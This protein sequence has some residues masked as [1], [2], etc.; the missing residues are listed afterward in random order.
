MMENEKIWIADFKE[1]IKKPYGWV[2]ICLSKDSTRLLND[3]IHNWLSANIGERH[4]QWR[5]PFEY[6]YWFE[7]ADDAMIFKLIWG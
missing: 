4:K 5:Y 1:I 3:E 2:E 6:V 7:N